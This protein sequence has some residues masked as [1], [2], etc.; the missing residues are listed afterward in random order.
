MSVHDE[1]CI[2]DEEHRKAMQAAWNDAMVVQD[3]CNLSGVVFS[4]A[5]HMETICDEARKQGQGT[6]WRNKHPIVRLFLNQLLHL[7]CGE[8]IP[9]GMFGDAY[10]EG[11]RNIDEHTKKILGL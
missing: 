5:R 8:C 3:A 6:E 10:Q 9:C 2:K 7:A 4:F 11:L 1:Q